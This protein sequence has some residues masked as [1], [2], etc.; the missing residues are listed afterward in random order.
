MTKDPI[1]FGTPFQP[2]DYYCGSDDSATIMFW[3]MASVLAGSHDL[4]CAIDQQAYPFRHDSVLGHL[5]A[6]V[7]GNYCPHSG[8]VKPKDS[9]FNPKINQKRI[10]KLLEKCLPQSMPSHHFTHY[11]NTV[12]VVLTLVQA[13]CCLL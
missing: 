11:S 9:P 6:H 3:A 4:Y 10:I 1:S 13:T 7:S 12:A 2:M 5:M 8:K